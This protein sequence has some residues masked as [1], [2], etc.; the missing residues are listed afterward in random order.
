MDKS[1]NYLKDGKSLTYS[2]TIA[3]T[4]FVDEL[5]ANTLINDGE[6]KEITGGGFFDL[7]NLEE[8]MIEVKNVLK[9]KK[10]AEGYENNDYYYSTVFDF[11]NSE[12]YTYYYYYNSLW[13]WSNYFDSGFTSVSEQTS[14]NHEQPRGLN[15]E[16]L[17]NNLV[18]QSY[19][20][21]LRILIDKT[22]QAKS[23]LMSSDSIVD[24]DYNGVFTVKQEN[25]GTDEIYFYYDDY[26]K[27][28]IWNPTTT[29]TGQYEMNYCWKSVSETKITSP[30]EDEDIT[31]IQ[32]T[33]KSTALITSLKGKDFY[34]GV[35]IIFEQAE[36]VTP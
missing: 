32:L 20:L 26:T 34:K 5:Y 19:N 4:V 11:K 14:S 29:K 16:N 33:S 6:Y 9:S 35:E 2:D 17:N 13:H 22:I 23:H 12:G 27:G 28:W 21:G 7:F 36:K 1:V 31:K 30:C 10:A 18:G 8:T 15:T 3:N 25:S 24:F